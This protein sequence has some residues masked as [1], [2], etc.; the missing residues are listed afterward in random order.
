VVTSLAA[1]A[2]EALAGWALLA[3][4]A[5]GLATVPVVARGGRGEP[6]ERRLWRTLARASAVVAVGLLLEGLAEV[7]HAGGLEGVAVAAGSIAGSLLT[8]QALIRWNRFRSGSADP[9]DWL[10]GLSAAAMIVSIGLLTVHLADLPMDRWNEW[11]TAAWL[12]Q[13]A[14]GVVV[15][16]T[17][18][19]LVSLGGLKRDSRLW[20]IVAA[21]GLLVVL[22]A[23]G[24]AAGADRAAHGSVL[25]WSLVLG[26]VAVCATR[27]TSTT[28]PQLA[29]PHAT[30]I[31]AL[32]V[33]II[34]AVLL[35]TLAV[36]QPDDM[37]VGTL[38]AIAA[39]AAAAT[40]LLR[41]VEELG[42]LAS[43]RFEA[44]TD[45][46]TGIA[47]RRGLLRALDNA[48]A[49]AP[50]PAALSLLVIDLDRF[51][52]VNDRFGHAVGDDV[53]RVMVQRMTSALG[54][55]GVLARLGGD[56]FAAV[57]ADRGSDR[58]AALAA[59]LERVVREPVDFDGRHLQL[60]CSIGIARA[61]C[62]RDAAEADELMRR[63]DAAMYAAKK[64]GG[65][66]AVYD[67][68]ADQ[69]ARDLTHRIEELGR[70]LQ[71]PSADDG[72]FVVHYQPQVD[73]TSGG[74][75]GCEAL[76]RWEHPVHGLL[77]PAAFIDLVE[78]HGLMSQ[79]TA[80]VLELAVGDAAR[81]EREGHPTRVSVNLSAS[82]LASADLV[83]VV[84]DVLARTGLTPSLLV[85]EIT[86]T[87]LM[88]GILAAPRVLHELAA[89]GI[90]LSV[91]DFGTG[92]SSLAYLADLPVTEL[93][94][95][96]SFVSRMRED[97]R[98][99]QVVAGTID[100]AHR[101]ELS[102]VAEGVEDDPTLGLLRG[103]QCDVSQGFL[104][105][106]PVPPA[107]IAA[108]HARAPEPA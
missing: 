89:R 9:G 61:D 13:L 69:A 67:H 32:V 91:D 66:V 43:S 6:A 46:L 77:G 94:I 72:R 3:T 70:A 104:H 97:S 17:S 49:A 105:A 41:V 101:L 98:T 45:D 22:T 107:E 78:H 75:V 96:R 55:D 40:R 7:L 99:R 64:A 87:V 38:V 79:L 100:L 74:L 20:S 10:N 36:V 82:C 57:L 5:L 15:W 76:V 65:G 24:A 58:S 28:R 54:S 34:G 37:L 86:E 102:V 68:E 108:W 26:A 71:A 90:R 88:D 56:E 53:L 48:L 52:D 51:K 73:A 60:G 29:T 21:L 18:M 25:G 8:Y 33:F 11:R 35:S 31:G 4:G 42:S 80:Q 83:G 39:T 95:D 44:R 84:D 12:T 30:T 92:Y 103:M 19:T 106:R 50:P 62:T 47:N 16:G 85:L 27:R 93:K 23:V 1:V 63:A 81:W 14:L 2:V 59:E